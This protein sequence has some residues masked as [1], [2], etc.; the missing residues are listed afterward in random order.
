VQLAV[1]PVLAP[2]HDQVHGPL[3]ETAVGVPAVQR[4]PVGALAR[5]ALWE[6]PQLPLMI[7]RQLVLLVD[8]E[9]W[10]HVAVALPVQP[11][12]VFERLPL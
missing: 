11:P 5:S 1:E 2:V 12:V 8:H 4:L 9:P 6:E 7:W 10:V 3:P